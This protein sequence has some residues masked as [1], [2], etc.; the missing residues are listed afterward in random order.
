[1]ARRLDA[2]LDAMPAGAASSSTGAWLGALL[3]AAAAEA[4]SVPIL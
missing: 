1:M 3:D 2:R 4:E